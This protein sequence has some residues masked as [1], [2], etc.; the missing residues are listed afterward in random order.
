MVVHAGVEP[1]AALRFG[2]RAGARPSLLDG[3]YAAVVRS[4]V[5]NMHSVESDCPTRERV[6]WTGDAQ[7]ASALALAH[8]GDVAT[9]RE[10]LA[11]ARQTYEECGHLPSV[12]DLIG[13]TQEA[14]A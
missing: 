12:Q 3:I 4:L 6:G 5:S 13:R 7:L 9:A 11:V 8:I 2:D 10:H 14:C 1:T